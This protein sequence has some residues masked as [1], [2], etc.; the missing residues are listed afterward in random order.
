[1]LRYTLDVHVVVDAQ[2]QGICRHH[3]LL[4]DAKCCTKLTLYQQGLHINW[5][6]NFQ[7]RYQHTFMYTCISV[8]PKQ[9]VLSRKEV[10]L[11]FRPLLCCIEDWLHHSS[12][13]GWGVGTS[14][15]SSFL[16]P[17]IEVYN[18]RCSRRTM[19][20]IEA[21]LSC[22]VQSFLARLVPT[23]SCPCANRGS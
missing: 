14:S 2:R 23:Y 21:C 3:Y 8:P 6:D 22:V 18:D 7:G 1:M 9:L 19:F 12:D 10:V 15:S 5:K 13:G 4:V 17:G 20:S 11:C 16:N